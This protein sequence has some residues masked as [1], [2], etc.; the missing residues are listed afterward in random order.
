MECMTGYLQDCPGKSSNT[1]DSG[2]HE[3]TVPGLSWEEGIWIPST[4]KCMRDTPKTVLGGGSSDTIDSEVQEGTVPGLSW[5]K[6]VWI[7]R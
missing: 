5:G 1:K 2:V 6:G 3:G 4:V 7:P